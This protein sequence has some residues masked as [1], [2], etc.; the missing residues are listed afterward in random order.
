[1]TDYASGLLDL[2]GLQRGRRMEHAKSSRRRGEACV[3]RHVLP[4][5]VGGRIRRIR[6]PKSKRCRSTA[7][8]RSRAPWAGRRSGT[9]RKARGRRSSRNG[10]RAARIQY[11]VVDEPLGRPSITP[12]AR[13]VLQRHHRLQPAE[14]D[15]RPGRSLDL[16]RDAS[17][18]R[19]DDRTTSMW[20]WA[21][22]TCSTSFTTTRRPS[23]GSSACP[24]TSASR[25]RAERSEVPGRDR[26]RG[27]D[28]VIGRRA[29][30]SY[31]RPRERVREPSLCAR[32]SGRRLRGTSSATSRWPQSITAV[33][34]TTWLTS[35]SCGVPAEGEPSRSVRRIAVAPGM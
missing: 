11:E 32:A 25:R 21:R 16:Q 22:R 4:Y 34:R 30:A 14:S 35:A 33:I 9:R 29:R 28:R 3:A 7:S 1:M 27:S 8:S 6:S 31:Y 15:A 5:A 10:R 19:N 23:S 24:P 26:R 18:Y 2:S 13:L 20:R 12:R 17:P